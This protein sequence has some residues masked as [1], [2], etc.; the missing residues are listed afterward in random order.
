MPRRCRKR[1]GSSSTLL[2]GKEKCFSGWEGDK[3][4]PFQPPIP[5][6]LGT[7][8]ILP[9]SRSWLPQTEKEPQIIVRTVIFFKSTSGS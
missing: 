2:E 7:L 8:D 4:R 5:T 6:T 3:L 1:L 9:H